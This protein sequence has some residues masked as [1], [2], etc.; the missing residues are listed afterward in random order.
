MIKDIESSY[1][2]DH[3]IPHNLEEEQFILAFRQYT[4][5]I[6]SY[7]FY[8]KMDEESRHKFLYHA[9]RRIDFMRQFDHIAL[10]ALH[11]FDLCLVSWPDQSSQPNPQKEGD[12]NIEEEEEGWAAI[13][14]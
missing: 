9:D 1:S 5:A 6:I 7:N 2:M 10:D 11:Y 8:V 3:R 13:S 4:Q 14:Q 12:D